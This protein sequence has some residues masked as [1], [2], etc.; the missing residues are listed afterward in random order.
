MVISHTTA[1]NFS[2]RGVQEYPCCSNI[3]SQSQIC[4]IQTSHVI[5]LNSNKTFDLLSRSV[6]VIEFREYSFFGRFIQENFSSWDIVAAD[7]QHVKMW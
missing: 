6:L 5:L 4:R 2:N 7:H 3:V 1:G